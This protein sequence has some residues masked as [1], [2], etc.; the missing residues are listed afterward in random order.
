MSDSQTNQRKQAEARLAWKA[1]ILAN[2]RD[3]VIVTD[4]EG[5][6]TY[7]NAGATKLLGWE[8]SE[9]L[10]KSIVDRFPENARSRVMEVMQTIIVD[11]CKFDGEWADY[12]K[13]G[14][15]IWIEVSANLIRG[16]AGEPA[17]IVATARDITE[18][19]RAEQE[20]RHAAD[21]LRAV[22]DGTTDAVFVKD[23]A[24][25]YLLFNE[26]AARYVGRPVQEVLGKDD[27]E[28]FDAKS[29]RFVMDRD[30]RTMES[31]RATTVEERLTAAGVTRTYLATK[32]PYRD[33]QG[34]I[35]GVIG[36][37]Q[38]ITE[39]KKAQELRAA[40]EAAEAANRA[41]DNFLAT[42][43]HELR[44]P[45]GGVLLWSKMLRAGQ[46]GEGQKQA[47]LDKI[48]QCAEDQSRLVNDLLD[49]SQALHGKMGVQKHAV[50]LQEVVREAVDAIQPAAHAKGV[51]VSLQGCDLTVMGDPTRLRQVVSNLMSNAIK[52]T[53]AGGHVEARLS[54]GEAEARLEVIDTGEGISPEF[55]PHIFDR[56]TQADTS[57]SRQHGGLGLGLSIV[58]HIVA[59]H[60]GSVEAHSE[61]PG[62]GTTFTV[63]L[64]LAD[65]SP[66]GPG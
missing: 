1:A 9:M 19:R 58:R 31:G 23:K 60:D 11:E 62:R 17:A 64:P 28:L 54:R 15:R 35:I 12:R 59:L 21:L 39:L 27:T 66:S 56:F 24:G 50:E 52:F 29:A 41:K 44:T 2:V 49:A 3:A 53:Q 47:A 18:H 13:D 16:T 55:L 48:V 43:S 32:A 38:E 61:G 20:A 42:I 33:G 34:N 40:K 22:A 36:I 5:V 57:P 65:E 10:G 26:A 46:L 8:G 6:V 14:S 7:W 45:L 30:R 51:A 63:T 37:S 25:K 4:L